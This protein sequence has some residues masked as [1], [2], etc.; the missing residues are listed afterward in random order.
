MNLVRNALKFTPKSGR[1]NIKASY[2]TAPD[3][4][5]IVHVEDTGEGITQEEIPQLFTRFGKQA[6]TAEANN[7]KGIGLGLT[8]VKQIVESAGGQIGVESAGRDKGSTF[9]I[10]MRMQAVGP[11]KTSH[12]LHN[13][14]LRMTDNAQEQERDEE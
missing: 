6:R 11:T 13:S 9:K 12:Q 4:L 1:I 8:M 14:L 2:L 10:S 5:L 3:E 7:S